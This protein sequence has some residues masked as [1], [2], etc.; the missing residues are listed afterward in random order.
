MNGKYFWKGFE[1]LPP[2]NQEVFF[3]TKWFKGFLGKGKQ[4]DPNAEFDCLWRYVDTGHRFTGN[5][6]SSSNGGKEKDT[7]SG[8]KDSIFLENAKIAEEYEAGS[9]AAMGNPKHE[10]T[11]T[12]PD[13]TNLLNLAS[14]E[15][16]RSDKPRLTIAYDCEFFYEEATASPVIDGNGNDM[17]ISSKPK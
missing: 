12:P 17:E 16:V 2:T 10:M 13:N 1:F 4:H 6:S 8:R 15:K 11:P 5:T 9:Q 14:L 7:I 3:S